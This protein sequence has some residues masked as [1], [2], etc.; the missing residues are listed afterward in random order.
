[1]P[2]AGAV[3]MFFLKYPSHFCE[4]EGQTS[5]LQEHKIFCAYFFAQELDIVLV[6]D[7]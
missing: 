4:A 7:D 6:R 1:M 5:D 3:Y 2:W